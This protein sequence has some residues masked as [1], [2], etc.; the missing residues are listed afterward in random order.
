[1]DVLRDSDVLTVKR[2]FSSE[3]RS[4]RF[5]INGAQSTLQK[6]REEM[7]RLS[8]D[9]DNLCTFMPQDRVGSFSMQTPKGILEKTLEAIKTPD[10]SKSY[11]TI[12][13]ELADVEK[14]KANKKQELDIRTGV[15]NTLQTRVNE[16]QVQMEIL[17]QREEIQEKLSH[18]K[19]CIIVQEAQQAEVAL[20]EK[21][22]LVDEAD[23]SL[24]Q[25][26]AEIQPLETAERQ[27]KKN[28]VA[29]EQFFDGVVKRKRAF[30]DKQGAYHSSLDELALEL[31]CSKGNFEAS[32]KKQR[33]ALGRRDA[34]QKTINQLEKELTKARDRLPEINGHLKEINENMQKFNATAIQHS[35]DMDG[36]RHQLDQANETKIRATAELNNLKDVEQIYRQKL[37]S[38]NRNPSQAQQATHTLQAMD[39]VAKMRRGNAFSGEVLG[40]VAMHLKVNDPACAAIIEKIVPVNRMY[41]FVARNESDGDLLKA[42]FLKARLTTNI[43]TM[44]NTSFPKPP[45]VPQ[46]PMDIG[47]QG[48]I[49]DQ[50]QCP[51]LIRAFLNNFHYLHSTLWCRLNDRH[52]AALVTD[53]VSEA[54]LNWSRAQGLGQQVRLYTD[55][56]KPRQEITEYIFKVS[57]YAGSS[58]AITQSSQGVT[59]KNMISNTSDSGNSAGRARIEDE[60]QKQKDAIG[61]LEKEMATKRAALE[62]SQNQATQLKANRAEALKLLQVPKDLDRKLQTEN[63]KLNELNRLLADGHEREREKLLKEYSGIWNRALTQSEK[64]IDVNRD[65]MEIRV[66]DLLA[67]R[68]KAD[69][70]ARA[71][72]ASDRVAEAKEA[73]KQ[74]E[75]TV[76]LRKLERADAEKKRNETKE[77]VNEIVKVTDDD[78][79][80]TVRRKE[81]AFEVY[82]LEKV[83]ATCGNNTSMRDLLKKHD[84]LEVQLSG[85]VENDG[86]KPLFEK[87]QRE[88]AGAIA[89]VIRLQEAYDHS[90]QDLEKQSAQWLTDVHGLAATINTS[91]K[92]FMGALQYQ[93]EA[94][95]VQRGT[96]AD[97]E[98]E[99]KVAFRDSGDLVPLS[100]TRHSGG[101]RAVSTIMYLMALQSL[102]T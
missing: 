37:L 71:D 101:E 23:T 72:A 73:L 102:T 94:A 75:E 63:G 68:A 59:G 28:L 49:G 58:N 2:T 3:V 70:A 89:D 21:Q 98:M 55:R 14:H 35:A 44:N 51:D 8:I 41:G 87:Y 86:A 27:A 100:G 52:P 95:L 97:F 83:M 61:R 9:M 12:Q 47:V 20:L 22:K 15:R 84:E 60:I 36:I 24:F 81:A 7:E 99:M 69:A 30:E 54:L 25:A 74:F 91:F 43:Y 96:F 88:L 53:K 76:R 85:I 38:G 1:M 26:K 16:M 19:H 39:L 4:C 65:C 10:S 45:P 57:N 64:F 6:V 32:E 46:M 82:Y 79:E 17:Q 48:Y 18:Y 29:A 93:G 42:E 50:V 66:E 77:K 56:V 90:H 5:F 11:R 40:P 78:D 13:M 80:A 62:A 67:S 92:E 31:D 33:E 34:V